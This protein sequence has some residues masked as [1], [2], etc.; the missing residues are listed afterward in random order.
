[1]QIP[2]INDC[3][4]NFLFCATLDGQLFVY[5]DR[6]K[7]L[8][9]FHSL[10]NLLQLDEGE[11]D[12]ENAKPS[13]RKGDTPTPEEIKSMRFVSPPAIS[14][15]TDPVVD[16]QMESAYRLVVVTNKCRCFVLANLLLVDIYNAILASN[17]GQ[18]VK[19]KNQVQV[20]E[21]HLTNQGWTVHD[22]AYSPRRR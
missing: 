14:L 4:A 3:A 21:E 11:I 18:V 10:A 6:I 13:T 22:V 9:P 5:T 15:A 17:M 7:K 19:L 8:I 12:K 1:M 16:E 2:A 20:S